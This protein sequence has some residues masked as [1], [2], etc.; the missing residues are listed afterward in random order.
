MFE[1]RN[2]GEVSRKTGQPTATPAIYP[3]GTTL[4]ET[5]MATGLGALKRNPRMAPLHT[6]GNSRSSG[7]ASAAAADSDV[8]CRSSELI[9]VSISE[10]AAAKVISAAATAAMQ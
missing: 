1:V 2:H 9:Y 7:A 3:V 6:V 8:A 5:S 10:T 4:V